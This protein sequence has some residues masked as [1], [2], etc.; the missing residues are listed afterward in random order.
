MI[1]RLMASRAPSDEDLVR[2]MKQCV[3][4]VLTAPSSVRA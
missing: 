3:L 4:A 2:Q 1:S